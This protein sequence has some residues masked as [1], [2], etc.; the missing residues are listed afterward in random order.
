MG[1]IARVRLAARAVGAVEVRLGE[2]MGMLGTGMGMVLALGT[3]RGRLTSRRLCWRKVCVRDR[4]ALEICGKH[5]TFVRRIRTF[6]VL[7]PAAFS[8]GG[9]QCWNV[10][11]EIY[12]FDVEIKT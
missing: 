11:C 1:G 8:A 7:Q 3:G 5:V 6:V 9:V 12:R 4:F 2:G 10:M